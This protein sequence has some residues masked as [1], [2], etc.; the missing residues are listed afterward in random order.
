MHTDE[1][2]LRIIYIS[3]DNRSLIDLVRMSGFRKT[4]VTDCDYISLA[5]DN[6]VRYIYFIYYYY[7]NA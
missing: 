3:R 2:R 7:K 4:Q 6:S 1:K 5:L